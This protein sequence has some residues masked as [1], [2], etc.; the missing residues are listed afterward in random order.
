M[1]YTFYL[2]LILSANCFSQE[3]DKKFV[4]PAINNNLR[5]EREIC[6]DCGE[7]LF[8]GGERQFKIFLSRNLRIQIKNGEIKEGNISFVF[9]IDS[10]GQLQ[11]MTLVEKMSS[12]E[13]CNELIFDLLKSVKR[14][15]PDCY[16]DIVENRIICRNRDLKIRIW[17]KDKNIY[18]SNPVF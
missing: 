12:C 3:K 2:I 17:I 9:H 7:D 16:Y 11:D 8:F 5:T 4:P 14:W 1:R 15:K 10:L 13:L 6:D 18:V